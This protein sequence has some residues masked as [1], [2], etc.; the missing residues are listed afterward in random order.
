MRR[1]VCLG[2]VTVIGVLA[3]VVANVAQEPAAEPRANLVLHE[4]AHNLYMLANDPAEQGMRSGGNT[5]VFLTDSGVALVDTKIYGY[6]QDILAEIAKITP[7]PVTT[8]INTHTHYDHSGGNVEFSD[9]VNIVVHE[10]TAAQMSRETCEPVTNCDAFKG[11]NAVY[12]PQTTFSDRMTL[13]DGRDAVDLYYFGRG[14]T[15]GDT[16]IVFRNA[17]T[18][19]TGDMFARKGLPFLDVVNGNGSALEFGETLRKAVSGIPDV[20]II[21]PGHNDE[22]LVWDDLVNYSTFYNGIV[23]ST[24]SRGGCSRS[25]N[26][27]TTASSGRRRTRARVGGG[28]GGRFL[29]AL[30]RRG[31]GSLRRRMA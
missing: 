17:R 27:S 25:C 31:A 11:D 21:I 15:D 22:T 23:T 10:N 28:V 4:V 20:D 14:H 19:H 5:A 6:G 7:K 30:A 26:T 16:W 29:M 13:F 18:L 3:T 2:V 24:P 9:T 12:L 8:I 1:V